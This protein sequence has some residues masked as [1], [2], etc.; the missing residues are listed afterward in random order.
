MGV[1]QIIV[2]G[3]FSALIHCSL[4]DTISRT[5]SVWMTVA[6]G[7]DMGMNNG[8]GTLHIYNNRG[9]Q[10]AGARTLSRFIWICTKPLILKRRT[11]RFRGVVGYHVSLTH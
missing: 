10:L 7:S 8:S 1:K 11:K 2:G 5:T 3:T 6:V 9:G 4:W